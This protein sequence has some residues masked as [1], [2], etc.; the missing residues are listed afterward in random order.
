MTAKVTKKFSTLNSIPAVQQY[1]NALDALY[2]VK[3]QRG[4]EEWQ[5]AKIIDCRPARDLPNTQKRTDYSYEYYIHYKD[6]NRRLDEWVPRSRIELTRILIEE[7]VSQKKK[8]KTEEHRPSNNVDDEH[9]N[10]PRFR[11]SF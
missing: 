5:L 1:E 4:D 6:A 9:V 2:Y 3:A 8:K 11:L 10:F 7:E